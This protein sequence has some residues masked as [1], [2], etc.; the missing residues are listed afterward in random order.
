MTE[1]A[2]TLI[3]RA[4]LTAVDSRHAGLDAQMWLFGNEFLHRVI[5]DRTVKMCMKLL[6]ATQSVNKHKYIKVVIRLAVSIAQIFFKK[7]KKEQVRNATLGTKAQL[8]NRHIMDII[9]Q[10]NP[11]NG[12]HIC[13]H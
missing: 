11:C 2:Y 9:T 6:N 13:T 12:T 8:Q 10:P 3:Q 5:A 7:C 1:E 4:L